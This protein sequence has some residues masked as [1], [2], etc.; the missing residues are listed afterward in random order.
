MIKKLNIEEY[1][2]YAKEGY[3]VVSKIAFKI[4][5]DA[6]NFVNSITSNDMDKNINAFLDSFGKI[7]ALVNQKVIDNNIVLFGDE[8]E[9]S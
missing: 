6:V 7:I 3:K 2:K 5:D 4:S 8:S 9:L 1:D